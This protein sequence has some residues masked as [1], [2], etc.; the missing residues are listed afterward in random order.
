MRFG[1]L[2][3]NMSYACALAT[4]RATAATAG[5]QREFAAVGLRPLSR[6]DRGAIAQARSYT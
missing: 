5:E 4:R 1:T 2:I 3:I 6:E